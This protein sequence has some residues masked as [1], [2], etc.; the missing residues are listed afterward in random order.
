MLTNGTK[1]YVRY[2]IEVGE[3]V[4]Y[5]GNHLYIILWDQEPTDQIFG[6][7]DNCGYRARVIFEDCLTLVAR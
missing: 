3:V 2:I 7:I 5:C 4:G 1:V 6:K